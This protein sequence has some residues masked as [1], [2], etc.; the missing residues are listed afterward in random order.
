MSRPIQQNVVL[1]STAAELFNAYLDPAKHSAFTGA[2]V[3]IG[4]NPGDKFEAFNGALS[5]AIIATISPRL[6]V[7]AWRSTSFNEA[8]PDSTLVL[9]FSDTDEGGRID[10]VH[11]G[12]PEHDHDGVTEGWPKFYWNP[13]RE[14]LENAS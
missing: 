3:T 7:Q 4:P 11:V 8:D 6:I 14:H 13:W 10:L 12:V 9:S 5:G 1:P 2:P